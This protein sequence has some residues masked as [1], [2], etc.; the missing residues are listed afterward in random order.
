MLNETIDCIKGTAQSFTYRGKRLSFSSPDFPLA[1]FVDGYNQENLEETPV[2]SEQSVASVEEHF[3]KINSGETIEPVLEEREAIIANTHAGVAQLQFNV[4]NVMIPAIKAMCNSYAENFN[5]RIQPDV[6][7]DVF[8]Y[9]P[10]HSDPEFTN[11]LSENYSGIQVAPQYRTFRLDAKSAEEIID[12][13][14]NNNKHFDRETLTEW[15]LALGAETITTVYNEL[16]LGDRAVV[17]NAMRFLTISQAPFN[18]DSILVAYFLLAALRDNPTD[19]IH[20]ESITIDVWTQVMSSL[21]CAMGRILLNAYANRA[22]HLQNQTLVLRYEADRHVQTQRVKV[23][24]NGD[25]SEEWLN[26]N[27][28]EVILGAAVTNRSLTTVELIEPVKEALIKAWENTYPLMRQASL[29]KAN[30]DRLKIVTKAFLDNADALAGLVGPENLHLKVGEVL[31]ECRTTDLENHYL[32][33]TKLVCRISSEDPIYQE[34]LEAIEEYSRVFPDATS[35]ELETQ[36]LIT[37]VALYMARQITVVDYTPEIDSTPAVVE[38]VDSEGSEEPLESDSEESDSEGEG[39]SEE[40][41]ESSEDDPEATKDSEAEEESN[42]TKDL[43]DDLD[44]MDDEF[45]TE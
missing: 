41:P 37:V 30:Q 4:H 18:T 45:E 27:S 10:I 20:G 8:E 13:I 15:M 32:L 44:S 2:I 12:F 33:F 23:I 11:H 17:L 36:A 29:D 26:N 1:V 7:V 35:R 39:D 43:M 38:E 16:F 3:E 24:L 40:A 22:N 19:R 5:T 9:N 14:A 31:K 28:V 6:S 34:Y 21:H 25:V 42:E